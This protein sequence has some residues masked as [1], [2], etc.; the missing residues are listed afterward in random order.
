MTS[1]VADGGYYA[2]KGFLYQFDKSILE[3]IEHPDSVIAVETVEDINTDEYVI[4]V[5]HR[6]TQKYSNAKVRR[7]VQQLLRD[8]LKDS[9]KR[10][11][12]YCYF[13]DR[14]PQEWR[15]SD[16]ELARVLGKATINKYAQSKIRQFRR[17]LTIQF[18]NDFLGQFER[19]IKTTADH[20]KVSDL[21]AGCYVAAFRTFAQETAIKHKKSRKISLGD[22]ERLKDKTSKLV[23]SA[24]YP[25]FL[26]RERFLN[27]LKRE[28]FTH[29][30]ANIARRERMFIVQADASWPNVKV[31]EIA[32]MLGKKYFRPCKSPQPY[33]TFTGIEDGRLADIKKE[34]WDQG[35]RFFDGTYFDGDRFRLED[36]AANDINNDD[37]SIKIVPEERVA[38]ISGAVAIKEVFDFYNDARMQVTSDG[39]RT[40]ISIESIDEIIKLIS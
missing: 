31:A 25:L 18:S 7:P 32:H 39:P 2:I 24:E 13:N 21:V 11:I 9:N 12:L 8:Y 20:F 35:T 22:L 4:Q 29:K 40:D 26:G 33:L 27:K 14:A 28:I 1:I 34:V 5:K 37:F 16:D 19:L 15:P 3:A 10:Y 23:F 38:D 30:S 6:E 17:A 36:I